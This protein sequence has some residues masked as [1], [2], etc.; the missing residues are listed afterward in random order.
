MFKYIEESILEI[1]NI[2][3]TTHLEYK[4]FRVP[5]IVDYGSGNNWDELH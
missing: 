2:M 1:K 5:L 3:E 4:D